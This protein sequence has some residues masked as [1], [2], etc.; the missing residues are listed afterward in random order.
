MVPVIQGIQNNEL[1]EFGQIIIHNLLILSIELS[2]FP[3]QWT[4][5]LSYLLCL[6]HIIQM[7]L[8]VTVMFISFL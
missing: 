8:Y 3:D 5:E 1:I 4:A 6:F 7:L 2:A